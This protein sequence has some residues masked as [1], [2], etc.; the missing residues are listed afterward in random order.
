[1]EQGKYGRALANGTEKRPQNGMRILTWLWNLTV[2]FAFSFFIS[3][4]ITLSLST[5]KYI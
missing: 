3:K 1:M 4:N 2:S 5:Y